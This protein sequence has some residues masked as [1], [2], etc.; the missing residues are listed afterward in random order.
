MKY[1]LALICL[2]A[3]SFQL[4]AADP[5]PEDVQR[6]VHVL[7]NNGKSEWMATGFFVSDTWV[8]TAAHTFREGH[9]NAF[10]TINGQNTRVKIVR[11]DFDKDMC[12]L[13]SPVP[14]ATFFA[15]QQNRTLR[16]VGF[17]DEQLHDVPGHSE[18]K[19]L[20]TTNPIKRGMSGCPLINETGEVVG[21]GVR[22]NS[23]KKD[24]CYSVTADNLNAFIEAARADK[25]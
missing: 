22:D 4:Q 19:E 6:I 2:L 17:T 8:M 5:R 20:V 16:A 11:L 9:L 18:A 21:M 13:E 15:I 1:I 14:N 25:K 23:F 12:L 10:L 24:R 7:T 3:L